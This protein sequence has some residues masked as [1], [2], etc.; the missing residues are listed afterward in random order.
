VVMIYDPANK[1]RGNHLMAWT[2]GRGEFQLKNVPAGKYFVVV[3]A[4]GIIRSDQFDP[5]AAQET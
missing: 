5:E 1:S 3:T 2:N 4:P